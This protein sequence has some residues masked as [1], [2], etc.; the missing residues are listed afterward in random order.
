MVYLNIIYFIIITVVA[1]NFLFSNGKAVRSVLNN[2]TLLQ[3]SNTEML[4]WLTFSTGLIALSA[5][6][7]LNLMA[8]RLFILEI[9]CIAGIIMSRN[10]IVFSFPLWIYVA[11]LIWIIIGIFYSRYPIYGV[12]TTLKYLYPLLLCLFASTAVKDAE[13]FLKSSLWARIIGVISIIVAFIP[14]VESFIFPGVFWYGTARAINFI[15]IMIFSLGMVLFSNEKKKNII[16]TILFLLPCILWVFRTSIMGSAIALMAFAL[17][18]YKWKSIP[19]IAAVL[20]LGVVSVFYIPSIKEKM[21]YDDSVTIEDLQEGK[22]NEDNINT[23]YRAYMWEQMEK[24]FYDRHKMTGSGTGTSQG[25]MYEYPEDFGGLKILHSDFEQQKC[26]NGD[27]ALYL[28]GAMIL[29][30]FI[31]CFRTYWRVPYPPIRLCALVAGA[32]LIGVYATFYSDNVVN[33]SMATL[34]MPFG[35]YGM[36]LGMRSKWRD[37]PD[38]PEYQ[39]ETDDSLLEEEIM[40]ESN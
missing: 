29:L 39:E 28:Y 3:Y 4:W 20:V 19:I 25:Y 37:N 6:V 36:M 35:F 7:G 22:I 1:L 8:I 34:S 9:L 18:R 30:I 15:S 12:R 33:Y 2:G 13:V 5:N 21:F 14:F 10:R 11:Y 26:D 31:D 17:I 16:F 40:P 24:L 23:N 27:I 32:S 38:D